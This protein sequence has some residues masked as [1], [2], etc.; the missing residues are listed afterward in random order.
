VPF[1]AFLTDT[2]RA[3]TDRE[4]AALAAIGPARV[5]LAAEAIKWAKAAPGDIDD[6]EALA[7][8]ID[9]WRRSCANGEPGK[10]ELSREAFRTLHRLYPGSEWAK[11]T[12]YWYK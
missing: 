4:I 6:A 9:G 10:W 5:Y 2:E 8:I 3:A 12:M 7:R 11:R 1:P